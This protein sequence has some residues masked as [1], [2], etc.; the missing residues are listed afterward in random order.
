[1]KIKDI[2][3]EIWSGAAK[4]F[5]WWFTHY[6]RRKLEW[7]IVTYTIL[8][9]A[10]LLL[11]WQSM[12][13]AAFVGVL[14]L[15]TEPMWGVIYLSAGLIHS[16]ALHINGRAAWTPFARLAALILNSQVFLAMA[17]GLAESNPIGTGVINYSLIACI[18][19]G[20]AVV[21]AA[22]DCGNELKIWRRNGAR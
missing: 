4:L 7:C 9:G 11:P 21:S 12:S 6:E 19:C 18:F 13:S 20:A 5:G 1:M 22:A 8:F 17:L 3:A 14:A 16:C 2:P 10:S 15:A